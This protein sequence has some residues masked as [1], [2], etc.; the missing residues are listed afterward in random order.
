MTACLDLVSLNIQRA[1]E[2]GIPSYNTLRAAL[3][4]K[5]KDSIRSVTND[6]NVR[7]SL[8]AY[9]PS[10][11]AVDLI[12]PWVG[13]LSEDHIKGATVGELMAKGLQTQFTSLRDG[14]PL[15]YDKKDPDFVF[16]KASGIIDLE[17]QTLGSVLQ[18][19]TRIQN[20][21][22][23]NVFLEALVV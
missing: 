12:D 2:H 6:A 7:K 1:M 11:A 15:F 5:K 16:A 18:W 14:D 9:G 21:E 23:R 20:V 19:S 8:T 17:N 3:G 22:G 4:L 13:A 10:K